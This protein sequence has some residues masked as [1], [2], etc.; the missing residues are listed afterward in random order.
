MNS[1]VNFD[2]NTQ[3]STASMISIVAGALSLLAAVFAY[4][5]VDAVDKRQEETIRREN[6]EPPSGPPPPIT[7]SPVSEVTAPMSGVE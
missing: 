3:E 5:V 7:F 2:P 1:R 6:L 4:F